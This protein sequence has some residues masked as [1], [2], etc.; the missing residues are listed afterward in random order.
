MSIPI[1]PLETIRE[2]LE[3]IPE[4]EAKVQDFRAND[5]LL[6]E[7]SQND[8][9]SLV[10]RGEI[11]LLKRNDE[12]GEVSLGTLRPGKFLGL[13]S[14]SSGKPSFFTARAKT[15]GT[16]LTI[17]RDRFTELLHSKPD[18]H[19]MISPLLLG[20]LVDRYR[21][22]VGLHLEVAELT[23]ALDR[24]KQELQA[25]VAQLEATRNRLIQQETMA[26]LGRLVA[27]IAHE[28]NNPIAS[29]S[30]AADSIQLQLDR[31][32]QQPV[33]RACV[34]VL[35]AAFAAGLQHKR[36]NTE[37]QRQRQQTLAHSFP[38]TPRSVLR[39][40]AQAQP[41]ALADLGRF[42]ADRPAEDRLM[43][44]R[45]WLDLFEAG[46][47]LRNV[48]LAS[49]RIGNIVRS[50]KGYSRQDRSEVG[51][52]DPRE[53]IQDTLVLFGYVLK[54]FKVVVELPEIPE[55]LCRPSEINQVWT[56]L[57]LNACEAMGESGTLTVRCGV[58]EQNW[59]W[60]SIQDDG[61][62]IPEHL[63]QRVFETQFT[64][65]EAQN[66]S[67]SGHGLGLAIARG[68]IEKHQGRI[69]VESVLN[70]GATFTVEL[71][72]VRAAEKAEV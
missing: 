38:G 28:I 64:T 48:Q 22:V 60:V 31:V 7:G 30:R 42:L 1:R 52:V 32:F 66:K 47:L 54:K 18:F 69:R 58:S 56:N 17:H 43:L 9:I 12:G 53:G 44:I 37:E 34:P 70:Q 8:Q 45:R 65:K 57:I 33:T 16:L 14:L 23:S 61:P 72:S 67:D 41:E 24:E 63:R 19:E 71:P 11:R 36:L 25:T 10:I 2:T 40:L 49:D 4:A 15:D 27:G 39:V 3:S 29:L 6:R 46:G 50:L 68:I 26:T 20:N 51:E 59:V 5:L 13:L 21:R 55:V 35:S 62:G